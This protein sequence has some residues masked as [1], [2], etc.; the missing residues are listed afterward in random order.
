MFKKIRAVILCVGAV[1]VVRAT[2]ADVTSSFAI[3]FVSGDAQKIEDG[4]SVGFA[5]DGYPQPT[6]WINLSGANGKQT[7]ESDEIIVL[8]SSRGTY[9]SGASTETKAGKILYNYLDDQVHDGRTK[10]AVKISGLPADKKYAVALILSGDADNDGFNG[11]YSPVWVNGQ[12]YS[13]VTEDESVS[14]VAGEEARSA[15]TWGNRRKPASGGPSDLI[16]GVNVMFVEGVSGSSLTVASALDAQDVSRLTIAGLQVWITDEEFSAPTVTPPVD[17]DVI[18]VNFDRDTGSVS[19]SAGLVSAANWHNTAGESGKLDSLTVVNGYNSIAFEATLNYSSKNCWKYTDNVNDSFL[20]GYL[21][22]GEHDGV[23]GSTITASDIPFREY[24]VIVY[25]ATDTEGQ[26]KPI[27]VNGTLYSGSAELTSCGYAVAQPSLMQNTSICTWGT[28]QTKTSVYGTNAIRIDG[29]TGNLTIQGGSDQT[30]NGIRNRGGIAAIQ[31]V[32][33]GISVFSNSEEIDWTERP[34]DQ[35]KISEL[36]ELTKDF[37]NL[38]LADGATLIVDEIREGHSIN[39]ISTGNVTIKVTNLEI[40]QTQLSG[41]IK[42]AGVT[43]TVTNYYAEV[44]G[45][46]V[47]GVTYPLIYRGGTDGWETAANWATGYRTNGETRYWIPYAGTVV[48]G[49]PDSNVWNLGLVDGDLIGDAITEGEDGYKV[50]NTPTLE[51]WAFKLV[52]ANGVHVKIPT[53]NKLQGNCVIRVDGT[54]KI[55][56][57]N[58]GGGN[59]GSDNSYY[60]EAENGLVFEN[61]PMPGGRVYLGASGSVVTKTFANNQTIAGVVIDVGATASGRKIVERKLYGFTSATTFSVADGAVTTTDNNVQANATL[62]L[63][64]VGDYKFDVREDGYYVIYVAYSETDEIGETVWTN[65]VGDGLWSSEGNWSRGVPAN[66]ATA[67]VEISGEVQLSIPESGV[68][69]DTLV[70]KGEGRLILSGGKITSSWIVAKVDLVASDATLELAPMDIAEGVAVEYTATGDANNSETELP[71]LTGG[72]VFSKF[73]PERLSF[74]HE[75]PC[76]PQFVCNEGTI[77]FKDKRYANKYNIVAKKGATIQ[78]GTWTG[79]VTSDNNVFRFEGG[80]TFWLYNGN[81]AEGSN[82][83]GT[84][85]IDSTRENPVVFKGSNYGNNSD[86]QASVT[87]NGAIRVIDNNDNFFTISGVVSDGDGEGDSLSVIYEA[88]R[89]VAFTAANTWTGGFNLLSGKTAKITNPKALGAGIATI[90]GTLQV[91]GDGLGSKVT[92]SGIIA[93]TAN[94][95]VQFVDGNT[96]IP[97]YENVLT[98]N[99]QIGGIPMFDISTMDLANGKRFNLLKVKAVEN[100]PEPFTNDNFVNGDEIGIPMGWVVALTPDGLGYCLKREAF[101]IRV[102]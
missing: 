38:T 90:D 65:A 87:G 88:N 8:W 24:S 71:A 54:S 43:G 53:L 95:T 4:T 102:R 79:S 35:I 12:T 6:K 22:D 56:V 23:V 68:T 26:F 47:D 40:T 96:I 98:V 51:G 1:V 83:K 89:T 74:N 77:R 62:A 48:P 93:A 25:M 19:E 28:A 101:V 2:T 81:Y 44:N 10:A 61:M 14:L 76:E 33:T 7:L 34:A 100:L 72:G 70:V 85:V 86:I 91:G 15:T 9:N 55:T 69:V 29:L 11:K 37:V 67:T 63:N 80:S 20:K 60:I 82:V 78:V 73:G 92:G 58:K 50:V 27:L 94:E 3:N 99:G 66:G 42:T 75:R 97:S 18:S 84:I 46:T 16:E 13:Y 31:I 36:P 59:N 52:V 41:M 45:Y 57:T 49:A 30:Y 39:I 21:D 64:Q 5:K 17:S 32:N